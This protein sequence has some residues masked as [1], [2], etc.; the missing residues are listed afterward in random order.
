MK[1]KSEMLHQS[2]ALGGIRRGWDNVI[3][4]T[5]ESAGSVLRPLEVVKPDPL[6]GVVSFALSEHLH[7]SF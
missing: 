7:A 2:P 1:D 4:E 6:V 3:T 5:V